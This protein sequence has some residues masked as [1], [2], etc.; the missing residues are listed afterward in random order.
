MAQS[1]EETFDDITDT[2]LCKVRDLDCWSQLQTVLQD[3][4][5]TAVHIITDMMEMLSGNYCSTHASMT[6]LLCFI[7]IFLIRGRGEGLMC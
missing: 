3:T 5:D 1:V 6:T 7:D 4:V 2:E